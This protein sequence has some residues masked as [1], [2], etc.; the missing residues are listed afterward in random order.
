VAHTCNPSYSGGGDQEDHGLKSAR[1]NSSKPSQ[2]SAGRVAHGVLS[3]NPSTAKKKKKVR[4]SNAAKEW[5][6]NLPNCPNLRSNAQRPVE[7]RIFQMVT[8]GLAKPF[9]QLFAMLPPN[10]GR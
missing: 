9:T 3:S 6:K 7:G 8:D 1:A 10:G 2:K 5:Q 4:N